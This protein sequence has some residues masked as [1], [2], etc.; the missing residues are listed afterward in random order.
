M[1]NLIPPAADPLEKLLTVLALTEICWRNNVH[2]SEWAVGMTDDKECRTVVGTEID[3]ILTPDLKLALELKRKE[4][5]EKK[6][7]CLRYQSCDCG[8]HIEDL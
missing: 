6:I 4:I 3:R 2:A 5:E 1:S 7:P 8:T